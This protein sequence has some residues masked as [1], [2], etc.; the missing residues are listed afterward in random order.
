MNSKKYIPLV[1]L[2]VLG[3]G[4]KIFSQSDVDTLS[5]KDVVVLGYEL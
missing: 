1:L 4:S 5:L 3:L 2:I